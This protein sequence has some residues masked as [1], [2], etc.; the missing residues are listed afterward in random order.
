MCPFLRWIWN[1]MENV[2]PIPFDEADYTW[3]VIASGA[4]NHKSSNASF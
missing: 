2:E 3:E 1:S 4:N